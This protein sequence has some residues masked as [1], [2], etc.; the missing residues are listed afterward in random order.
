MRFKLVLVDE[1]ITDTALTRRG[2][3]RII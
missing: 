2:L 3:H 1:I